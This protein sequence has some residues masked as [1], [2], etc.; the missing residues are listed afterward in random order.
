MNGSYR[1]DYD[2]SPHCFFFT[3][4]V[5]ALPKLRQESR[6]YLVTPC[7]FKRHPLPVPKRHWE[8]TAPVF[9]VSS[10][11]LSSYLGAHGFCSSGSHSQNRLS[12]RAILGHTTQLN[13][14]NKATDPFFAPP[15]FD[16][17][18]GCPTAS[19]CKK[20]TCHHT[21]IRIQTCDSIKHTDGCQKSH[22]GS[23]HTPLKKNLHGLLPF[24]PRKTHS[25]RRAKYAR[26][27][28]VSQCRRSREVEEDNGARWPEWDPW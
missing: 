16:F 13:S 19:V 11:V 18:N 7:W 4:R 12:L 15:F 20:Y 14:F 27:S 24:N 9:G 26:L 8:R 10:C 2:L 23:V 5:L 3:R 17:L 21:C 25:T 6:T 22:D 1:V 28:S